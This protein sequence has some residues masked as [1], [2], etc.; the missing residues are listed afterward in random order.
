[1]KFNVNSIYGTDEDNELFCYE[2]TEK[3]GFL[4]PFQRHKEGERNII[5]LNIQDTLIYSQDDASDYPIVSL[6]SE[7]RGEN[8]ES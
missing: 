5:I 4:C 6:E 2:A 1:M 3:Y 8:N 7:V